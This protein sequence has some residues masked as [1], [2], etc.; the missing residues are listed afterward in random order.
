MHNAALGGFYCACRTPEKPVNTRNCNH[1]RGGFFVHPSSFSELSGAGG[2]IAVRLSS[3]KRGGLEPRQSPC[4]CQRD[5]DTV[6]LCLWHD[7][8]SLTALLV[9]SIFNSNDVRGTSLVRFLVLDA[10]RS[11]GSVTLILT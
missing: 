5:Y 9:Q 11:D 1:E 10:Y 4:Q 6:A 8:V 7:P 3:N 2:L